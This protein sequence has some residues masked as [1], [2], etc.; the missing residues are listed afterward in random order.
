MTEPPPGPP[1]GWRWLPAG[2]LLTLAVLGACILAA[3]AL[4]HITEWVWWL[5][6]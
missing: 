3:Y 6:T 1:P 4:A 5:I 2:A